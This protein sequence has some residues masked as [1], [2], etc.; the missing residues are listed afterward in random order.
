MLPTT[1][2]RRL[3]QAQIPRLSQLRC[4]SNAQKL[5]IEKLEQE[6]VNDDTQALDEE[7]ELKEAAIKKSQNKSGLQPQHQNIVNNRQPF[8]E[9]KHWS[10]ATLKYQRK[11]YGKYGTESNFDPSLCWNKDEIAQRKE[12]E[13]IAYP[14]EVLELMEIAKTKRKALEDR[15]A[16][17]QADI[18]QKMQKNEMWKEDLFKKFAK[19]EAEAKEAKDRK[20][21]LIEEVRRHFG[22]T[23]DPRD[24]KFKEMLEKKE[25][26]QKKAMKEARKKEKE[27]LMMAKLTVKGKEAEKA[28]KSK[29]ADANANETEEDAVK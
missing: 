25:K 3:V 16:Q 5:N 9:P 26:E 23:V 7:A 6:S 24:D 10:H 8:E 4:Q 19:K 20:D 2:L 17:K 27:Q 18:A 21:R 11:I 14:K 12:Y 15:I 13:A 22:Y 1:F 28:K 29:Q